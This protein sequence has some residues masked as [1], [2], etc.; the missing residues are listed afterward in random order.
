MY[1]QIVPDNSF[2]RWFIDYLE[3]ME[4]IMV[5]SNYDRGYS[6]NYFIETIGL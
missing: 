5:H 3:G 1:P 2:N 6:D 4:L